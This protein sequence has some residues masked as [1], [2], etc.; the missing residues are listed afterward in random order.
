M[1]ATRPVT[2]PDFL[3]SR[4]HGSV[5]TQGAKA[6]FNNAADA[7]A[8]LRRGELVVGALPFQRGEPMAL[9]VPE[10][11]IWRIPPCTRTP[12]TSPAKAPT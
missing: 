10:S 4:P 5:R 3:L 11:V 8:A 6:T 7:V 12:S 2:A 9:T 1:S